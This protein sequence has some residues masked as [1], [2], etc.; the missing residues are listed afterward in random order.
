MILTHRLSIGGAVRDAATSLVL[1]DVQVEIIAGPDEF[2][3]QV[4]VLSQDA[5][6]LRRSHRL[7]QTYTRHNGL[8]HFADLPAGTYAIRA[9]LRYYESVEKRGIVVSYER[10][11]KGGL[12]FQMT[13]I[14]LPHR[15]Y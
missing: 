9:A 3:Q 13:D 1:S 12:P 8:Y 2:M 4:A 15:S 5:R 6:W 11:E 7:N 10:D 14:E